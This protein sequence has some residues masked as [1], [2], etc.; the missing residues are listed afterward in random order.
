MQNKKFY[1]E[2]R[3]LVVIG[4]FAALIKIV[5]FLVAITGGGMNPIAMVAKN[6]VATALLIILVFN[7]RKFGVLSLYVLISGMISILTMGRGL[8]LLPGI[9]I[10]GFFCDCLIK[11]CGGYKSSF[12]VLAG[13]ALFDICYRVIS[14]SLGYLF[15]RENPQLLYFAFI[16]VGIGYIGCLIGLF[17]GNIFTKELRHAGIIKE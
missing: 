6:I 7:V 1:W 3:E 15:M 9:L 16:T 10:A 14:L 13:V 17:T 11:I 8:M 2:T 5:S 12:A 4:T